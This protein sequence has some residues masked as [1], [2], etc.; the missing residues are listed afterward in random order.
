MVKS[1]EKRASGT[2]NSEILSAHENNQIY[3]KEVRLRVLED[4]MA[5]K[6]EN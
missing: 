5:K 2:K 3:K 1:D 6:W 4:L